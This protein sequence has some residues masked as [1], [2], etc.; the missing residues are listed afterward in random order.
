MNYL[1]T[2]K[3]LVDGSVH[4]DGYRVLSF[5]RHPFLTKHPDMLITISGDFTVS[6]T[7]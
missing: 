5:P 2:I 1:Q 4:V 7:A 6:T 3:L